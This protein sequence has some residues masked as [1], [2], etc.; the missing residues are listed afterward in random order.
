MDLVA[1]LA[2]SSA[3]SMIVLTLGLAL[4]RH[5]ALLVPSRPAGRVKAGMFEAEWHARR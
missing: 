4:R 2:G 3:W 5:L 1:R